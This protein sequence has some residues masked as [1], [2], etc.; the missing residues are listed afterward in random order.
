MTLV[1]HVGSP[2]REL[3]TTIDPTEIGNV[4]RFIN[5]SCDPNL[6][7]Q[8]VRVGSAVPRLAFFCAR[9]VDAGEELSFH[10]GGAT[11]GDG[12]GGGGGMSLRACLCGAASCTGFLPY[13]PSADH[14]G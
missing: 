7:T 11:S 5:H 12:G 9:D 2:R 1:E 6:L 13:D 14:N 3:H 4:G 10:Y 8:L